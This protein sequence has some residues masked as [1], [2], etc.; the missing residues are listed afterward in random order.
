MLRVTTY[1]NTPEVLHGLR[2]VPDLGPV[3]FTFERGGN[4][5]AASLTPLTVPEYGR[6]IGDLAHPLLPRGITAAVPAYVAR[7]NQRIWTTT[8]AGKRVF[9]IGYNETLVSTAAVARRISKA[10]KSKRLRAGIVDLRNN[11]GGDNH[12]YRYLLDALRRASKTERIVVLI[13]RMTFSAAENFA[14]DLERV[15][16]PIFVGEPSGGSPNLYGDTANTLLPVSGVELRVAEIYWQSTPD[17]PRIP[18]APRVPVSLSSDTFF[19]GTIRCSPPWV[20]HSV[21]RS[22]SRGSATFTYDRADRS[23]FSSA[24]RRRA[25]ASSGSR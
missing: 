8:L 14:T 6:G 13:S 15:A 24:R 10:A 2:L 4:R 5:F 22:C 23:T 9:Y 12:T 3:T 25:A 18:I 17:D 21:R 11:G 19:A 7:R 1:L 16:H 20:P